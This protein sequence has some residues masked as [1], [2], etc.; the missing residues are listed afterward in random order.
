VIAVETKPAAKI[1]ESESLEIGGRYNFKLQP[2]R[3]IYVGKKR[4]WH[5]FIRIG[6][7]AFMWCELLDRE[8]YLLE[9]TVDSIEGD[10]E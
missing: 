7:G 5:Q 10:S 9:E 6:Y 3:L 8:I 2:E 1:L 4:A